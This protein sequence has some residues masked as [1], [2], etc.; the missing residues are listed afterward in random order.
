MYDQLDKTKKE[1]IRKLANEKNINQQLNKTLD[2]LEN[3]LEIVF[4]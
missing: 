2:Q 1:H 3:E 4:D